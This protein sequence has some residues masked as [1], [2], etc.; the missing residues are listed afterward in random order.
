MG[1]GTGEGG[2]GASRILLVTKEIVIFIGL[3]SHN[4]AVLRRYTH[5]PNINRN[6]YLFL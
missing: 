4:I 2:G 1:V 6:G 5:T 3:L